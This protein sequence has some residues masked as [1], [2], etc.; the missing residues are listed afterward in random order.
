MKSI[1]ANYRPYIVC[2]ILPVYEDKT[3][4]GVMRKQRQTNIEAFNKNNKYKMFRILPK[5]ELQKL[6]SIGI[7]SDIKQCNYLFVPEEEAKDL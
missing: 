4:G 5:G 6:E 7:H 3:E 1:I 2:E